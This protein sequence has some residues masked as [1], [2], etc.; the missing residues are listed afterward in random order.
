MIERF[1]DDGEPSG[2]AGAP[3]LNVLVGQNL[4]NV[5]VIVTRYFGGILLR[6]WR[7]G[8]SL[9][10]SIARSIEQGKC[11]AK[12]TWKRSANYGGLCGFGKIKVLFETK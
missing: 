11:G 9:Y 12:G 7:I 10:N 4:S 8:Q 1:S 5:L 6:H 3:M 2:T